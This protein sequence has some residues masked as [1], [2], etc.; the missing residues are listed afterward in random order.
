MAMTAFHEFLTQLFDQ[1]RIVFRAAPRDR[2]S[3]S[4]LAVLAEAFE[5][6]SLAVAGCRIAFDAEIACVAA[7]FVRQASWALVNRD[8]RVSG[9][10][11]RMTMRG[12]PQTPSQHLSCDL[13]MRYLPQVLRRARG[14]DPSDPL[15]AE[16]ANLLRA[17]PL[18]G[19]LSDVAEGP[20]VP[21]RFSAHPG[22]M[23]LYAERL[24]GNDRLCWRPTR[25]GPSWE[26]YELVLQE[27]GRAAPAA[28]E[29]EVPGG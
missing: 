4:A 7:E 13:T 8:E 12:A 11:K 15:V 22:L 6:H 18:S 20:L 2:P 5:I 16:I 27:H 10:A 24:I 17:W 29:R 1:G 23:L 26:Y 25:N 19:V 14:L 21:P 9:L 28:D 3:A